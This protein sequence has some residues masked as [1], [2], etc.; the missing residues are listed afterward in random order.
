MLF[1]NLFLI[2]IKR[3]MDIKKLTSIS[4]K[5]Y[6]KKAKK[7][8]FIRRPKRGWKDYNFKSNFI[9]FIR[10]RGFSPAE[11]KRVFSNVI[12]NT[13]FDEGGR[14]CSVTL[15]IETDKNEEWTLKV[16]WGF[17]HNKRLISENRDL[18]VKSL[19]Q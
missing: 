17:D 7:Y 3:I 5:R 4:Q 1:K 8:Y 12:N 18:T 2:I 19:V 14:D 13:F 10:K 15:A 16:K 9:C 11:H 6:V